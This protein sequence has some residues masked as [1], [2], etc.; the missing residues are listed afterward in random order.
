MILNESDL[1]L[2]KFPI[3]SFADIRKN[4]TTIKVS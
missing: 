1:N 2:F 4:Y 3:S